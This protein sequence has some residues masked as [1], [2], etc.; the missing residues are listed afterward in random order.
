MSEQSQ[1]KT[2][3]GE[4]V[5]RTMK[6]QPETRVE[7]LR[8]FVTE[9]MDTE[10]KFSL[11][12]VTDLSLLPRD[13]LEQVLAQIVNLYLDNKLK[14]I[15]GISGIIAGGKFFNNFLKEEIWNLAWVLTFAS[16]PFHRAQLSQF[17]MGIENVRLRLSG[18]AQ[19]GDV[20]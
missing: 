7:L 6:L 20:T 9:W 16:Y 11:Q 8:D 18:K 15:Q 5:E 14:E 2:K 1:A 19:Q 12:I 13:E 3:L 4:L 10:P 17:W